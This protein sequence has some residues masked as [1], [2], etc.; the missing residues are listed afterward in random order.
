MKETICYGWKNVATNEISPHKFADSPKELFL[1]V[2]I[3]PP[4]NPTQPY[5]GFIAVKIRKTE[6]TVLVGRK[7]V[8]RVRTEEIK[9][10]Q[11]KVFNAY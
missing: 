9:E 6:E 10:L 3:K 4:E 1:S 8:V 7:N 11:Q 5:C 2:G